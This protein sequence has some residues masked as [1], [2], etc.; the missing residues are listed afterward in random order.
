MLNSK[1]LAELQN[2]SPRVARF[3]IEQRDL[4]FGPDL[5]MSVSFKLSD[6]EQEL[7]GQVETVLERCESSTARTWLEL[8]NQS[9]NSKIAQGIIHL[10]LL[11]AFELPDEPKVWRFANGL[12]TAA[13]VASLRKGIWICSAKMHYPMRAASAKVRVAANLLEQLLKLN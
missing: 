7:L 13:N 8:Q 6:S 1:Q 12:P 3:N 11:G 5:V 9:H 10:S 4:A 2:V